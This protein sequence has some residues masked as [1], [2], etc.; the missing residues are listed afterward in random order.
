MKSLERIDSVPRSRIVEAIRSLAD[1]P[2]PAGCKKLSGREGWRI[3]VGDYRVLY[4]IRD[5][6]L[7][8][9]VVEIG[10]RREIYR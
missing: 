7:L 2:R 1:E 6:V 3:R 4:D 5:E 8:I 10:H 9:V